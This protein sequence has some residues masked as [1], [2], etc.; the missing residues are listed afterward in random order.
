VQFQNENLQWNRFFT[1]RV[2]DWEVEAVSYFFELYFHVLRQGRDD[3]ICWIP[4]KMRKFE[5]K[6]Y[7]HVLSIPAPNGN[8]LAD[9]SVMKERDSNPR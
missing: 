1:R 8:G 4:S 3:R 6:S 7:Y 9:Q 5:V 2:H